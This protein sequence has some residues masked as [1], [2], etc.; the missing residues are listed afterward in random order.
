MTK[1]LETVAGLKSALSF[2]LHLLSIVALYAICIQKGIDT[3]NVIAMI[4]FSYGG[5]QTAKQIS[6]HINASKDAQADTVA[7]IREVNEK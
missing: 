6:A 3:S 4:A 5:T 7:A 2:V 1:F